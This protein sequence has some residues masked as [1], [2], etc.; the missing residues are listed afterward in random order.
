MTELNA[1]Y[2]ESLLKLALIEQKK[3]QLS[4]I[5][6]ECANGPRPEAL[7]ADLAQFEH[8]ESLLRDSKKLRAIAESVVKASKS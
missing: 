7:M 1:E 4:Y 2:V 5:G 3:S 8:I 6:S